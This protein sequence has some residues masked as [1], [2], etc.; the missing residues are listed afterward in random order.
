MPGPAVHGRSSVSPR[1]AV[2]GTAGFPGGFFWEFLEKDS[3]AGGLTT[4]GASLGLD[5]RGG[6]EGVY[7]RLG[8]VG[9]H[10]GLPCAGMVG[11][12][13]CVGTIGSAQAGGAGALRGFPW[14]GS[15]KAFKG[16]AG[17]RSARLG[18]GGGGPGRSWPPAVRGTAG[19]AQIDGRR[20]SSQNGGAVQ[21]PAGPGT[22]YFVRPGPAGRVGG[23]GAGSPKFGPSCT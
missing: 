19:P 23:L 13:W 5:L 3:Q 18:A 11:L 7:A 16:R 14:G 21:I 10:P 4:R 12:P 22:Q 20:R 17:G 1:P 15:G 6:L 8:A 9:F 2:V